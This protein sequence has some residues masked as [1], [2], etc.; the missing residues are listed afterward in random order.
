MTSEPKKTWVRNKGNKK[1]VVSNDTITDLENYITKQL[2]QETNLQ[3]KYFCEFLRIG[4]S[5][6]LSQVAKH[7]GKSYILMG[8]LSKKNRWTERSRI[9]DEQIQTAEMNARIEQRKQYILKQEE[10]ARQLHNIGKEGLKKLE[11][12]IAKEP[13]LSGLRPMEIL[14]F[15]KTGIEL[16]RL[17][18]GIDKDKEAKTSNKIN[19]TYNIVNQKNPHKAI[20]EGVLEADAEVVGEDLEE[21]NNDDGDIDEDGETT[22]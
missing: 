1:V 10:T 17:I 12:F 13:E 8:K 11:E 5:R 3:F 15:I 18:M 7:F 21:N 19:I 4:G 20:M 14:Q 2:P 6:S 16:E 9:Y 22:A